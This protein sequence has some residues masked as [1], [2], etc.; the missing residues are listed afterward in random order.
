MESLLLLIPLLAC[1]LGMVA[2]MGVMAWMMGKGMGG[3]GE[4]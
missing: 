3:G 2:M 1:P 4:R